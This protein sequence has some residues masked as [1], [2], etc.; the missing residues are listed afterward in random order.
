MKDHVRIERIGDVWAV[1]LY[2]ESTGEWMPVS[3]WDT[4]DEAWADHDRWNAI[5][6]DKESAS[7]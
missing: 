5:E 3:E 7:K 4:E 2:S 6:N 1:L